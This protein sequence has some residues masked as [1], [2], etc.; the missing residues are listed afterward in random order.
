MKYVYYCMK[1][2]RTTPKTVLISF[3][4]ETMCKDTMSNKVLALV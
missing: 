3:F 4:Y 2:Q 1:Q